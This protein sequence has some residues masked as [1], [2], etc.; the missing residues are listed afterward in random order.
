MIR[1]IIRGLAAVFS[2]DEQVT[3]PTVLRS[4]DGLV[5]DE[6]RFT[7]YLGGPPEEDAVAAALEQGGD[8]RFGFRESSNLLAAVTAYRSRCPL[9]DKELRLLVDYTMG[10]WSDGIGENWTCFSA[11][12]C[13]YTVMCLTAGDGVGPEY[14]T[15]EV[16]EE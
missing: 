8:I 12:K 15:V 10:Q 4:L 6:E 14:P 2:D 13:G 3:D 5:Y 16:I 1:I 9:N 7:D 11:D